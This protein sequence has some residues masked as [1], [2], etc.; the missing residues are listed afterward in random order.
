[1]SGL[2]S[3]ALQKADVPGSSKDD[4]IQQRDAHDDSRRLELLRHLNVVYRR[5]KTTSRM[6]VRDDD[7]RG[8]V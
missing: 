7:R 6:V 4:V 8:A 2:Q 1:M 5:L 3:P